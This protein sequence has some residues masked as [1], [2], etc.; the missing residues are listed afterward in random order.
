MLECYDSKQKPLLL[1]SSP[2]SPFT[3]FNTDSKATFKVHGEAKQS[4][5]LA[6]LKADVVDN[7]SFCN[8]PKADDAMPSKFFHWRLYHI[9]PD[10]RYETIGENI[11]VGILIHVL[12]HS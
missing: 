8:G 7:E 9:N 2:N 10:V 5:G 3:T 1:Y 4:V 11:P 12:Y 6:L